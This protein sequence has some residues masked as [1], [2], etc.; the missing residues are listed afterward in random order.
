MTLFLV[1][2]RRS[3]ARLCC[4]LLVVALFGACGDKG[5]VSD[6]YQPLATLEPA[7]TP[8]VGPMQVVKRVAEAPQLNDDSVRAFFEEFEDVRSGLIYGETSVQEFEQWAGAVVV[9]EAL[10]AQDQNNK[11][12]ED[13]NSSAIASSNTFENVLGV[14]WLDP[15]IAAFTSCSEVHDEL[16]GGEVVVRFVDHRVVV[17]VSNEPWEVIERQR[18]HDGRD[19]GGLSCV[20]PSFVERSLA[21]IDVAIPRA[22]ASLADPAAAVALGLDPIFGG[23]IEEELNQI[24]ALQVETGMRRINGR[25]YRSEVIGLD[26]TQPDFMIVVSVCSLYPD[27]IVNESADGSRTTVAGYEPGTSEEDWLYVWLEPVRQGNATV[28]GIEPGVN[29]DCWAS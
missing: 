29:R 20:A 13:A 25:Q 19:D 16:V 21:A 24:I 28:A 14:S 23:R 15:P 5:Q 22:D 2:S 3:A 4:L 6:I 7:A 26:P 12:V 18:R 11:L 1:L 17:D 10:A 8:A 27:G 9:Q